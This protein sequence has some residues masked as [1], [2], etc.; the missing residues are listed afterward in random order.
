MSAHLKK[1]DREDFPAV[2]SL[3]PELLTLCRAQFAPL[4]LLL[5]LLHHCKTAVTWSTPPC[6]TPWLDLG[7]TFMEVSMFMCSFLKRKKK[8]LSLCCY[9]IVDICLFDL[10]HVGSV[11]AVNIS[12]C[13]WWWFSSWMIV[14]TTALHCKLDKLT[15]RIWFKYYCPSCKWPIL[16]RACLAQRWKRE[17]TLENQ[18]PTLQCYNVLNW[19]LFSVL[20]SVWKMSR[21]SLSIVSHAQ[22]E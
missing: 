20:A 11:C 18:E 16:R 19:S 8:S 22:L 5:H 17:E 4:I 14:T 7:W 13:W 6:Q 1:K 9:M 15:G 3:H 10:N 21:L 12:C 2:N